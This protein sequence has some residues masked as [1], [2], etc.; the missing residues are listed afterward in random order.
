MGAPNHEILAPSAP[1]LQLTGRNES[2]YC[3]SEGITCNPP[4]GLQ[5]DMIWERLGAMS[6]GGYGGACQDVIQ[7]MADQMLTNNLMIFDDAADPTPGAVAAGEVT[8]VTDPDGTSAISDDV[9]F[10]GFSEVGNNVAH[11]GIHS[12]QAIGTIPSVGSF[13]DNEIYAQGAETACF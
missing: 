13:N 1:Q 12:G 6:G 5:A 2:G 11:E 7:A 8:G 3:G 10:E 4:N 9:F